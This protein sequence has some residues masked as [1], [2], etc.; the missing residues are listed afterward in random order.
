MI[1]AF[2]ALMAASAA[3]LL[4]V[5]LLKGKA[6]GTV[7]SD[8][9]ITV[10]RDQLAEL[11]RDL[12][13]GELAAAEAEAARTEIG[14]RMLAAAECAES[15][16]AKAL[17]PLPLAA[18]LALAVPALAFGLYLMLGSP[19]LPDRPFDQRPAAPSGQAEMVANMV[20]AL[21]ERLKANPEDGKGWSM[22]A[23]SYRVL[24]D[25]EGALG[26]YGRAMALLPGDIEI[27]LEYADLLLEL[28][29]EDQTTLPPAVVAVMREI[30]AI[31]PA[32]AEAL[33][34]AGLAAV[35][36]GNPAEARRMWT[37]ILVTLP[38]GSR[39]RDELARQIEALK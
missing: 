18:G 2:F 1:W 35:Q 7:R 11:D 14:R 32:N 15:T 28:M 16:P 37:K 5:P 13:R 12:G 33:Y 26:A 38:E 22:L 24:G 9:D 31:D 30:L 10:Y 4:I 25:A 20:R 39:G 23:R 29:P 8:Y 27:R 19:G 6:V 3:A 17:R 36:A 34:Y 21:S